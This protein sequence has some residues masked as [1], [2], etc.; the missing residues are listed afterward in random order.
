MHCLQISIFSNANNILWPT[1]NRYYKNLIFKMK[2][3]SLEG[4][5]AMMW[6]LYG[7]INCFF[8]QLEP[9]RKQHPSK[10]IVIK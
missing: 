10:T 9:A 4:L 3:K 7:E 1:L 5:K 2:S 6:H 8:P